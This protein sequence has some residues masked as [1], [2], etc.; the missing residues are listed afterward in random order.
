MDKGFLMARKFDSFKTPMVYRKSA[1]DQRAELAI[2]M[3]EKWGMVA[4]FADGED[5][6]GRSKTDLLPVDR[7]ID[8]AFSCAEAT[9]AE[10]ERRG[11]SMEIPA[12]EIE[13]ER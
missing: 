4:G 8:R 11:W 5:S 13:K 6:V 3:L 7:L 2:V 12:P 10:I 1:L 9:Y